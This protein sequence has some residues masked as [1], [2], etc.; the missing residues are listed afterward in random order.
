MFAAGEA[1]HGLLRDHVDVDGAICFNDLVALGMIAGFAE[2][3]REV[4]S[5]FKIVGF[6]DIEEAAQSFPAVT[7]VGCDIASFGERVA[8]MVLDWLQHGK[9][10]PPELRTPVELLVRGS[11][12]LSIVRRQMIWDR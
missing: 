3:G 1:A 5:A 6:D 10:P 2:S 11:S 9:S 7:S 8:A 4:G 12:H